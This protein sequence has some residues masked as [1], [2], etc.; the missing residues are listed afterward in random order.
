MQAVEGEVFRGAC[1]QS[2]G[3][4][5]SAWR[6]TLSCEHESTW[7]VGWFVFVKGPIEMS[8]PGKLLGGGKW[9]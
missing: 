1:E 6:R 9:A 5:L 2:G 7:Q 8:D 4:P 3:E